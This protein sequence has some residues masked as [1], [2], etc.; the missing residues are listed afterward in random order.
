MFFFSFHPSPTSPSFSAESRERQ[1]E[2]QTSYTRARSLPRPFRSFHRVCFDTHAALSLL[3]TLPPPFSATFF[4]FLLRC[5]GCV[6]MLYFRAPESSRRG[7]RDPSPQLIL[8]AKHA[9]SPKSS[10]E[11]S[12]RSGPPPCACT[13]VLCASCVCVPKCADVHFG[14]FRVTDP[15]T[16]CAAG[17]WIIW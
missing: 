13:S 4:K 1:A 10:C 7:S 11:P 2:A 12:G 6:S 14:V 16:A 8:G 17:Q 9:G 15:Q 5:L 3:L